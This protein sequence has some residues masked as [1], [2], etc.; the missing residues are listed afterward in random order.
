[1]LVLPVT[2][3]VHNSCPALTVAPSSTSLFSTTPLTGEGTGTDVW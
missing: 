1:M 3:I 2:V